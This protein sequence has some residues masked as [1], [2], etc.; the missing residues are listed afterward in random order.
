MRNRKNKKNKDG[1][2]CKL[3]QKCIHGRGYKNKKKRTK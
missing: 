3:C 1:N 2:L